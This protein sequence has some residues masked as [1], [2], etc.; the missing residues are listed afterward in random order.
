MK[1]P[2]K[3]KAT[4]VATLK[5]PKVSAIYQ[6]ISQVKKRTGELEQF[7]PEKIRNAILKAFE[8][9]G[10]PN[11]L[12]SKQVADEV[13]KLLEKKFIGKIPAVEHIQDLVEEVLMKKGLSKVA[14]AYILYRHKRAETRAAQALLGIRDELKLGFNALTVLQKRYLL[15]NEEGKVVE[16]PVQLFHRVAKAISDVDKNYG[17]TAAGVKLTEEEFY[18]MMANREFIPNTP[19]LMNAGTNLGLLSA[20]YVI[21]VPDSLE[22]IFTALKH[23]AIVQQQ[24]GGTGFSFSRLRPK[25]D[26]VKSTKGVA[27]GPV[28]F[29][30]IFDQTT[31]VIKQG[32]KRR[33]ANMGILRVDHPDI[34]E[35]IAA[36]ATPGVLTNF[37]VSVAIT[38]S[39]MEA[40]RKN[41][42]YDLINPR[43]GKSV[44]KL[45]AKY[46]WSLIVDYAWKT[47]DPGVIFIDEINRKNPTNHIGEIE[48]T[49]PCGEQPLHPYESCNL[50]SINLTKMTSKLKNGKYEIDWP[51]LRKT[52][53]KSVHFLDNVI[54]ASHF[55]IHEIEQMTKANRRIGLGVM[56]WADLLLMLGIR[57]DSEAALKLAERLMKFIN[58][59]AHVASQ[60]TGRERGSF[61]N[62]KGSL[63]DKLKIKTMRNATCTTIAPT[64]S[65]SIIANCSSGIE[66]LFAVSFVRNVLEG[67]RLLETNH[68]FEEVAKQKGF[69]SEELMNKI[70]KSGSIQKFKEIPADVRSVFV[71]ALDIKP[72]WHVKMQAAFQKYTDNAV[73]K[74]I[75]FPP[76]ATLD[77]VRKAYELAYK[78]KCKGITVYRYGSK[79]E[80]VLY[81]GEIEQRQKPEAEPYVIAHPETSGWCSST[82]CPTP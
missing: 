19:T 37:N 65:I 49:N 16:N 67:T 58:D 61:T 5:A 10:E 21:P 14:K 48:S 31:N 15:R 55:P 51:K 7:Q 68:I 82:L 29:A 22:G 54:D 42:E 66:P 46:V 45:R 8:A 75:N 23:M 60:K 53:H 36:K 43:T 38:D 12:K 73:S 39:F 26:I 2:K 57:Y 27:S 62:F 25:G 69:Y 41:Q 1:K 77:D 74:T 24:A 50:G 6:K 28:T 78:L 34:L 76:N 79:A 56:G 71:T 40:V 63:W 44:K 13:V 20:C 81:I 35:F 11:G 80:Q 18:Q 30:T 32:G 72:E 3:A 4:K 17:A 59:E 47:G 64:G 33:G 70:A 52:I 9:T